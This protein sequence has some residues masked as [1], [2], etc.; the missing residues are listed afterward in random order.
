M[1]HLVANQMGKYCYVFVIQVLPGLL[2][3]ITYPF[4][5]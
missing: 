5:R 4:V 2:F 1:V 3:V